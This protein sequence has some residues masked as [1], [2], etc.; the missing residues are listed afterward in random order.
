MKQSNFIEFLFDIFV[1][2]MKLNIFN[3]KKKNVSKSM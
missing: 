3:S 1:Q 2:K